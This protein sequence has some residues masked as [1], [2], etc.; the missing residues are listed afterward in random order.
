MSAIFK[1]GNKITSL[2]VAT[3]Q[4][5][6]R[7]IVTDLLDGSEHV[8]S[9]GNQ[10]IRYNLEIT[11]DDLVNRD[12]IDSIDSSGELLTLE[13]EGAVFHGRILSKDPWT[14]LYDNLYQT[15]LALSV[16]VI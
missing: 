8:Q 12:I 13:A 6:Q 16:E 10:K 3:R 11:V 9:V 15:T 14:K 5:A 2:V 7:K 4:P 1:D